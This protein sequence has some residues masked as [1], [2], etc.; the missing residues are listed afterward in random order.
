MKRNELEILVEDLKERYEGEEVTLLELD[1]MVQ[2]ETG[3]TSSLYEGENYKDRGYAF[4]DKVGKSGI[5]YY[6]EAGRLFKE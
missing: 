2:T 4:D 1:N 6:A 3:T 5:E